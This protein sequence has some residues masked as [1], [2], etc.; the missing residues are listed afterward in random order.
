MCEHDRHVRPRVLVQSV[1]NR[2]I[3]TYLRDLSNS[4]QEY[5]KGET[6]FPNLVT[7]MEE[8]LFFVSTLGYADDVLTELREL[9]SALMYRIQNDIPAEM[10]PEQNRVEVEKNE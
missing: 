4:I 10:S 5:H 6:D 8:A 2:L 3:W 1:Q 7:V 9:H